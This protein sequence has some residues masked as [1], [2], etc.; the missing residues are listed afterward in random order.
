MARG[1]S[2]IFDGLALSA[3]IFSSPFNYFIPAKKINPFTI[4]SPD[5]YIG[6]LFVLYEL[7]IYALFRV[8]LDKFHCLLLAKYVLSNQ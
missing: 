3:N 6:C 8:S 4:S 7:I 5:V 1:P 2:R